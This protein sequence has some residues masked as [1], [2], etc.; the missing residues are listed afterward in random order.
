MI[1]NP[2][3]LGEAC[4]KSRQVFFDGPETHFGGFPEMGVPPSHLLLIGFASINHP[5]MGVSPI[6]ANHH[7]SFQETAWGAGLSWTLGLV[8]APRAEAQPLCG[9]KATQGRLP[10]LGPTDGEA[11]ARQC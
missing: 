4:K 2:F 8:R 10:L 11:A 7:L 6:S 1:Q 5:A 9:G 3:C